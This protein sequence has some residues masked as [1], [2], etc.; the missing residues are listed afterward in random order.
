MVTEVVNCTCMLLQRMTPTVGNSMY[1]IIYPQGLRIFSG[2]VRPRPR[3]YDGFRTQKLRRGYIWN[4]INNVRR[5]RT[6]RISRSSTHIQ[7]NGSAEEC[8]GQD[9]QGIYIPVVEHSMSGCCLVGWATAACMASNYVSWSRR[10][11]VVHSAGTH[12][13]LRDMKH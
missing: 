4:R 11:M 5:T 9:L 12:I 10:P 7:C 13:L 3:A 2:R 1:K 6:Q 8:E